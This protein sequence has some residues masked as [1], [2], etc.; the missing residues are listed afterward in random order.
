MGVFVMPLLKILVATLRHSQGVSEQQQ[1]QQQQHE[2]HVRQLYV[3][4]G[5]A[6]PCTIRKAAV[7]GMTAAAT[8]A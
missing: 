1:Q 4:S 7:F 5:W 2:A 6:A 8:A 3:S